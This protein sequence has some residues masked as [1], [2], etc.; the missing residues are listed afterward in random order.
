[1]KVISTTKHFNRRLEQR[2]ERLPMTLST[3]MTTISKT[4]IPPH[5]RSVV[6]DV[7]CDDADGND[8]EVPFVEY[9]LPELR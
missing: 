2:E 6:F 3:L 8:V 1:L 9:H 5:V 4:S 7:C